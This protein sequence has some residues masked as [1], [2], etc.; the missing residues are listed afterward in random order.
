MRHHLGGDF[1]GDRELR[2]ALLHAD[3]AIGFPD[4]LQHRG[5]VHRADG[6]EV[7]DLGLDAFGGE[8]V[9]CRHGIGHADAER[10][11]GDVV[12]HTRDARLAD[13]HQPVLDLGDLEALAV[14]DLVL[15]EDHGVRI[16][17]GGLQEALRISGAVGLHHLEAGDVAVPGGIVLAVL[18]ADAGRR[19]GSTTEHDGAVQLAARHVMGLGGGVDDLVDRLHGEIEGHELDNGLQ[20]G[21]GRTHR[22][23]G[24]AMLGDRRIDHAPG[25]ELVEHPLRNLVGALILAHFL[26]HQEDVRVAA[27]FLRHGFAQRLTHRHGHH[28]GAFGHFRRRGGSRG[29]DGWCRDGSS[30]GRFRRLSLRSGCGIRL[31]NDGDGRV[32]LHVLGA[33]RHENGSERTLVHGFHFHGGLVGLDLG[34][35]IAGLHHVAHVLEP[36]G[37]LALFHGGRQGGHED[38]W[39]WRPRLRRSRR[40]RCR[41]RTRPAPDH[42]G[43]IPRPP[44]RRRGSRRRSSSSRPRWPAWR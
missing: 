37:E 36:L 14:E 35:D 11:D 16:T 6:A 18:G 20:P 1:A 42:S 5:E 32:D 23:A 27:H 12:A 24:E 30:L 15:E 26:A 3:A 43:R 39:H 34:D 22:K 17:N 44:S 9:G 31:A 25:A 41:A 4:T 8:L 21:E 29:D 33:G 28:L 38:G 19:S 13:R 40:C 10:D 2:E 7:D